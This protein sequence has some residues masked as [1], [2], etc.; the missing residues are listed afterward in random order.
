MKCRL[1]SAERRPRA[2]TLH[3]ARGGRPYPTD[4]VS[5]ARDSRCRRKHRRRE[6]QTSRRPSPHRGQVPAGAPN[7]APRREP[8][9]AMGVVGLT[10]MGCERSD[11]EVRPHLRDCRRRHQCHARRRRGGTRRRRRSQQPKQMRERRLQP[12]LR[13]RAVTRCAPLCQSRRVVPAQSDAPRLKLG[14]RGRPQPFRGDA[15]GRCDAWRWQGG[16]EAP[17]PCRR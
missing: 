9:G 5:R 16:L 15:R 14:K 12:P 7:G 1:P 11:D 6:L 3:D 10:P 13:L 4:A 17:P 8:M 2:S